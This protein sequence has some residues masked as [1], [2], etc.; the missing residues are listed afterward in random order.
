MKL[1]SALVQRI[2]SSASRDR[3][4]ASSAAAAQNSTAKIPVA[5]GIHGILRQ[6][7]LAV[8]VHEPE[9]FGNVHAVKRQGGPGQRAAAERADVHARVA[10]PEPFAIAFEHLHV[11]E[12]VVREINRLGALQVG[13]AGNQHLGVIFAERNQRA[14]QAGDFAEQ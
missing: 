2:K 8:H 4:T 14:L 5:Y 12:Q 6:L 7:R 3:W 13:V 10:V 11:G 1:N 9:Q